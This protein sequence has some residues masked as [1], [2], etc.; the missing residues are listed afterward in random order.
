MT[1]ARCVGKRASLRTELTGVGRRKCVYI[2][3]KVV[4]KEGGDTMGKRHNE[5]SLIIEESRQSEQIIQAF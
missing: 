1:A 5:G 4:G 3:G 2:Y